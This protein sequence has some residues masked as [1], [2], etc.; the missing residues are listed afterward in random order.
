MQNQLQKQMPLI[1]FNS[2]WMV[3]WHAVG[4]RVADLP[5]ESSFQLS[6]G[7]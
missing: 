2:S 3:G 4:F 1:N 7:G 6:F 5:I